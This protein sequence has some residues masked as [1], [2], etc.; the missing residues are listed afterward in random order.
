LVGLGVSFLIDAATYFI[1]ISYFWFIQPTANE[2][3]ESD[4]NQSLIGSMQVVMAFIRS[5][6]QL[7]TLFGLMMLFGLFLSG[8]IRVGFPL[9][10]NTLLTGGVRY[11][12]YMSS[13]FGAGMLA[14]MVSLKFLPQ[15]PQAV[16]GVVVLFLFACLPA[17][18]IVLGLFP[19]IEVMLTTIFTMGATFGYVNIYLL[20]WLQRRTPPHLLGRMMAVVLFSTIGLSP[21]SQAGVGYLLDLNIQVTL[22]GIGSLVLL[23]LIVT[24]T[25]RA[26]WSLKNS[27]ADAVLPGD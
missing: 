8:A 6:R 21:V 26:M 24:G 3:T 9:L 25:N 13:A 19:S 18:L 23:L 4:A 10:A 5:D 22:I 15:P 17:G 16:S 11:F 2:R 12:G 20:S 7:R 14:G 27:I 1:G